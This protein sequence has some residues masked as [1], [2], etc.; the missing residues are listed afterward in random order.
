M[1][2]RF[3]WEAGKGKAVLHSSRLSSLLL[4]RAVPTGK[5]VLGNALG[6]PP[7]LPF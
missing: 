3:L 2:R 4:Q 5:F 7:L 6:S 1:Y